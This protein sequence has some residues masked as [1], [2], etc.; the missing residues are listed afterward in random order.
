MERCNSK[1]AFTEVRDTNKEQEKHARMHDWNLKHPR[2]HQ[3]RIG[4]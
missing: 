4:G 3:K 1:T 2:G